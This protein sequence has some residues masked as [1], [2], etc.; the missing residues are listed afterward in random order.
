M[1]GLAFPRAAALYDREGSLDYGT[2]F[3]DAGS[4]IPIDPALHA[5]SPLDP[6]LF[7]QN[8]HALNGPITHPPPP[9][10]YYQPFPPIDPFNRGP[11]GD[12]FAP[13]P[14]PTFIPPS[15]PTP[16]VM[17][18]PRKK[19]KII[20]ER[21]CGFCQ[22]DDTRNA[23]GEP[24][25]LLTCSECGR[26]G[27]PTCLK[28]DQLGDTVRT[29][30]W[31]CVDCTKCEKCHKR[32]SE[33]H[34]LMCD[35][36][37]RG[38]HMGCLDPPLTEEPPGNWYCPACQLPLEPEPM[39]LIPEPEPEPELIPIPPEPEAD[40]LDPIDPAILAADSAIR[41]SSVASSSRSVLPSCT[42]SKS[43]RKG[44]GR[45]ITTD[46]SEIDM[47]GIEQTPTNRRATN[48]SK[49]RSKGKTPM[50]NG[51]A[52]E[53]EEEEGESDVQGAPHDPTLEV[54]PKRTRLRLHAP[55]PPPPPETPPQPRVRLRLPD[56]PK[57]KEKE[58][59]VGEPEEEK[60]KGMFDDLLTPEDR[61]TTQ[62][63]ITPG[64]KARFDKAR[65]A[66]DL[67]MYPPPPTIPD[68]N[69]TPVAGPSTRRSAM[70]IP[71]PLPPPTPGPSASPAPST[72]APDV[73]MHTSTDSVP[74]IR[75]IRFG[76][77]EIQTWYNAPFPEEYANLPD[78]KLWICEFC[79]KYMKSKF[80]ATR[81]ELKCKMRHPPGDEIYRDGD[82]S[83]YE[84]DGRKN[85]IYCQNLCLL[86][87]MFLDHKSL[88]YDVEPFLFY[89][90]TQVDHTG[91]RFVG[92]F[93]KEKRSPKDYNV[94]CIM[95][96]PVRQRQG[97]GNLL[98]DFSYLLSKKEHR[99]GS[100]EKPLSA[101]GALGYKNYWTL[102]LMRYLQTAPDNPRLED[103]SAATAMTI[104]D[105]YNTLVQQN[106]ITILD[107]SP[108]KP[109]PG[110]AIRFPKGRKNGIAR[111]HLQR[112]VTHDD[113]KVK[114]PFV[115]PRSYRIH[116]DPEFV[117]EYLTKWEGKGYLK[118]K[119]ENLRWSPF[120]MAR[121]PKSDAIGQES[122]QAS[123]N[124]ESTE[125]SPVERDGS[126]DEEE[127]SVVPS[128]SKGKNNNV[129]ATD[130][131]AA[132]LFDDDNIEVVSASTPRERRPTL[133][134][135]KST[136]SMRADQDVSAVEGTPL[137]VSPRKKAL[138]ESPPTPRRSRR[139]STNSVISKPPTSNPPRPASSL[140]RTKSM[141]RAPNGQDAGGSL[142]GIPQDASLIARDAE[143]AAKVQREEVRARRQLRSRSNTDQDG[144]RQA[145]G[146]ALPAL[147]APTPKRRNSSQ[148]QPTMN[149][150]KRKRSDK[151]E[152]ERSSSPEEEPAPSSPATSRRS[153]PPSP[154]STRMTRQRASMMNIASPALRK[155]SAVATPNKRS[156]GRRPP[157]V[158]RSTKV[159]TRST[160]QNGNLDQD[161]GSE[162]DRQAA[163]VH[164]SPEPLEE[165][166]EEHD[167]EKMPDP[168]PAARST[169]KPV[170][171][172]STAS[173][174]RP[175]SSQPHDDVKSETMDTP[176]TVPGD[177]TASRQSAPSDDTMYVSE[178]DRAGVKGSVP[179]PLVVAPA[180]G[181]RGDGVPDPR[182]DGAAEEEEDEAR[183]EEEEEEEGEAA[184]TA[185]SEAKPSDVARPGSGSV[186]VGG[187]VGDNLKLGVPTGAPGSHTGGE[188][189][190]HVNGNGSG[191]GENAIDE[192]L[193]VDAEG[194]EDIDAEG[195]DDIDAE[196]EPD[197]DAEGEPDIDADGEP[198]Y[199]ML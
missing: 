172:P 84:V 142:D 162:D 168:E 195:D 29:Y 189:P 145:S 44:K 115:P 76:E 196:G 178:H 125:P 159:S 109:L 92:Y 116:W 39:E 47:D 120:I 197:I 71:H 49:S 170:S 150:R 60:K 30:P 157:P 185:R 78:G 42:S 187:D 31:T 45:A 183:R 155:R 166:D 124:P 118:L 179:P 105:I 89:V 122:V 2:P 146:Y 108:S 20:I 152:R 72:P 181:A 21:E 182:M 131:P 36:C 86:S 64:D 141:T 16:P 59:E 171:G 98:I 68:A 11:Q 186:N 28:L 161:D 56:R 95:T 106:M 23:Q 38:W 107:S 139:T 55:A 174:S 191:V 67:K 73:A 165:H 163:E 143:Y 190:Q 137:R 103:I 61:D 46:D 117:D 26:S 88:F 8:G 101:L 104:E 99:A 5:P 13:Q 25:P 50:R 94:S 136:R 121:T 83:I 110:Q 35:A 6:A 80:V 41:E 169:G 135:R 24:E 40:P 184:T 15:A 153:P 51:V 198:D 140:R 112:T 132:A 127:E 91:A 97:W 4:P 74:R 138:L 63:S 65:A 102:A 70:H 128:S 7:V 175:P 85:K 144:T 114:G 93:S 57:G 119:P 22:G 147:V 192:D 75:T 54:Q 48:K 199:E 87:K 18:P 130:S 14:P 173:R 96:L 62:T 17:K 19:R 164:E 194:E 33:K 160:R 177:M 129:R 12:P 58:R 188:E 79:L 10:A 52:L 34:M 77:F 27:H 154:P 158:K 43:R 151:T 193:D 66:A 148:S 126:A 9:N 111:K 90:M 53:H 1:R 32:G 69:A 156:T 37:D 113:E 133:S 134:P 180:V 81:H 149:T 100:P 167:D 123:A 176:L 3:S 82:I